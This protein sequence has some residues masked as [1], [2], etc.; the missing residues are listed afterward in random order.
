M[1][2]PFLWSITDL[3]DKNAEGVT[4]FSIYQ[5]VVRY[6]FPVLALWI[7]LRCLRSMLQFRK[8]P[9]IW[10]WLRVD[11]TL[12][13][14]THWENLIGSGRSSDIVIH[15]P[16]LAK[17]HAVLTR[18]DDGS[19][20]ISDIGGR[21]GVEVNG[22]AVTTIAPLQYHDKIRLGDVSLCLEPVTQ[23][24]RQEGVLNRTRAGR[25]IHPGPTLWLLTLFQA[26]AAGQMA[27]Q[28]EPQ[29]AM[30]LCAA[31]AVL[32]VVQW[33]L[34]LA[35][36]A[37][38]RT[39]FEIETIAF[40]LTTIG[41]AVVGSSAPGSVYKQLISVLLGIIIYLVVGWSLRD[42]ER[43]KKIRYVA[44]VLGV[45]LLLATIVLGTSLN[46]AK[47]W[48]FIGSFS[49]QPS[50][51]AKLCFIFVGASTMDRIVTKRNLISFII[52]SGVICLLLAVM[53]DFGTAVIFFVAFLVI[54]FLRSGSF[55]A[56]ALIAAATG[57]AGSLVLSVK[58]YIK[59]RFMA[60]GHVWDYA[61]D[62]G[63]QQTQAMMCIAAGGLFGLG[64]GNG[65]LKYVA[66]GDTDLVFGMVAEEWGLIMALMLVVCIAAMAFF[67]VRSSSVARSS[68]YTIGACAAA[69][70]LVTQTILNVFGTVDFLPLTGVTFPFVSNGGSSMLSSWGLLAFIKAADT[71]QNASFAVRLSREGENS[72]E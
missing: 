15:A 22:K 48:I 55:A 37:F 59:R 62:L 41:L 27:M 72:D 54:A 26:L 2:L 7:L 31:F 19:W 61:L 6:V 16:E 24:D 33:A 28:A 67:V 40:F 29:Y 38:H 60:W 11:E 25:F 3:F 36:K 56:I 52:Y 45:G 65:W 58:P 43:A 34:F 57:F 1:N 4:I 69:T 18:Y 9:E 5:D 39:G 12:L 30:T 17:H 35:L 8:E 51:L 42:L 70:I 23:E 49:I 64:A 66:A 20:T 46:G 50:E 71:R 47:N 13:P 32:C 21:G 14:V 53:S 63:Y 10:A 44:A 68:F